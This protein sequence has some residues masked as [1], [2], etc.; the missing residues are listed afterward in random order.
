MATHAGGHLSE[1]APQ[2][3]EVPRSLPR[4][5][6]EQASERGIKHVHRNEEHELPAPI[7]RSFM[8]GCSAMTLW[9]SRKSRRITD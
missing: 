6:F 5:A 3:P 9:S 7:F 1:K 8:Q 2:K 4:E